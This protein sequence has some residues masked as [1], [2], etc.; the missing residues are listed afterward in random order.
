MADDDVPA[1]LLPRA[2]T[3]ALELMECWAAV[4]APQQVNPLVRLVAAALSQPE[5]AHL[6]RV[7]RGNGGERSA[8]LL[9]LLWR[10]VD[11]DLAA[12][13]GSNIDVTLRA[14]E[15]RRQVVLVPRHAPLTRAQFDAWREHW[16][17]VFH[18][19]AAAHALSRWATP[20]TL[21]ERP[22][23]VR[24]MRAA[25]AVARDARRAGGHG[26]GALIVRPAADGASDDEVLAVCADGTCD[27]GHPL[28]HAV[29]RCIEAVADAQRRA[30]ASVPGGSKRAAPG[31]GDGDDKCGYLCTGC[32]AYV[33]VEPCAMCAMALLHSRIRRVAYALEAPDGALGSLH[34]VHAHAGLNHHF[35]VFRAML[36]DEAVRDL[37]LQH[38]DGV[39][40]DPEAN[41][42]EAAHDAG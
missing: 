36:R 3:R 4:C 23:M 10:A 37:G 8:E 24:H 18:E 22:A 30:A 39:P 31:G 33:T 1:P 42:D 2:A 25:V 6:K 40:G 27:D 9:V 19:S 21:A 20:A 13:P 17:L 32:D 38:C 5:L 16:P 34:E 26:V 12:R 41:R 28:H 35:Q 14:H 15:L 11:A 29:M 7:H